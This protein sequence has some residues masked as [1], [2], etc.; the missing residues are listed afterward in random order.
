MTVWDIK[1]VIFEKD[2]TAHPTQ[3]PVEIYK[4]SLEHHTNS[5]EYVY[6][7]FG[8]SGTSIIACEKL[9][10]RSLSMELDPKFCDVIVRRWQN[11]TGKQAILES[12]GQPFPAYPMAINPADCALFIDDEMARLIIAW[13][14]VNHAKGEWINIPA[15]K[16]KY[17][18]ASLVTMLGCSRGQVIGLVDRAVAVGIIGEKGAVSDIAQKMVNAMI[19][20][21]LQELKN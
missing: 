19:G 7:P 18:A 10:R 21:R 2:K 16:F 15:I 3:K 6:E 17:S 4:R 9:Q 11:Y 12:T 8:G 1:S 13:Q 5:G 20:K 14:R